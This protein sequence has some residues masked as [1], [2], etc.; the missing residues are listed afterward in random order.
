MYVN[1]KKKRSKA[2]SFVYLYFFAIRK[3]VYVFRGYSFAAEYQLIFI[4]GTDCQNAVI[5]YYL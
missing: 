5:G 3:L 2:L 4:I 1:E